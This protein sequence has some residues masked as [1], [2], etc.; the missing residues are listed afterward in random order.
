VTKMNTADKP[1]ALTPEQLAAETAK[2]LEIGRMLCGKL[3]TG[4]RGK[5]IFKPLVDFHKNPDRV[6]ALQSHFEQGSCARELIGY[7]ESERENWKPVDGFL[8]HGTEKLRASCFK[9]PRADYVNFS[10]REF[11]NALKLLRALG[12]VSPRLERNGRE[13][14]ILTPHAALCHREGNV[15]QYVGILRAFQAPGVGTFA[16]RKEGDGV[17][18]RP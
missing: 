1:I 18:W 13:G 4:K 9:G 12:M 10:R 14:I 15:C 7:L 11:Y 6:C 8:F 5:Q 3:P 2:M 17:I 16:I